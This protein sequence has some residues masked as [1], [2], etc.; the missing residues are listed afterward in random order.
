MGERKREE[1]GL[2]RKEEGGRERGEQESEP[3]GG[4]RGEWVREG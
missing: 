1:R 4:R 2:V 3:E